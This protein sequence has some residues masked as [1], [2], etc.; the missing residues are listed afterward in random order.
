[1]FL[2]SLVMVEQVNEEADFVQSLIRTWTHIVLVVNLPLSS[3]YCSG[4]VFLVGNFLQV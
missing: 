2:Q 4:Q 3:T 1:M